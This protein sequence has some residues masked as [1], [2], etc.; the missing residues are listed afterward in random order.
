MNKWT[1]LLDQ[2]MVGSFFVCLLKNLCNIKYVY[3]STL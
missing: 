3:A 2:S 1:K